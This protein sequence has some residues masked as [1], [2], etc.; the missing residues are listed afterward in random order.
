MS[1]KI[2]GGFARGQI[3]SVPKGDIIRPTSVMLRRRIFDYFQNLGG[4]VFVDLCA[5][6]GAMGFEAW[7]RGANK[8]FLNE[9]NR[10]VLKTLEENRENL[11]LKSN[12]KNAGEIYCSNSPAEKFIRQFKSKYSEF[13]ENQKSETIIFLDP[14]YS[15]KNIYSE[16]IKA[17]T[18]EPWY[19]GQ[20]WIE[21]DPK[22]G[23]PSSAW[24]KESHLSTG[25]L[26]EQGE[27]YIFVTNFPQSRNL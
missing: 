25:K 13:D 17:I 11:L 6:S 24:E 10:H 23:I 2:L 14:P 18:E 22:K 7:S 19:F 15:M 3:L 20:L 1:I 9:S 5:G 16:V 12:Y 26:F 8:V 27:S 4:C 21:S